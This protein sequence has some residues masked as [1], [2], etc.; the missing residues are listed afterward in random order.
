MTGVDDLFDQE[1][2]FSYRDVPESARYVEDFIEVC[3]IK[4]QRVD[5]QPVQISSEEVPGNP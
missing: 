1:A 2:T 3:S 5:A 4:L